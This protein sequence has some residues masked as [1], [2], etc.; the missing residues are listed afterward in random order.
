MMEHSSTVEEA[1]LQTEELAGKPPRRLGVLRG[2]LRREVWW[3]GCVLLVIAAAL[4]SADRSIGGGDTWVA[5]ANGRY[6]CAGDWA[7]EDEGRT[8]Q[9]KVLDVFGIHMTKKD[10]M[11][12]RTREYVPGDHQKFGWLNQNWLT[13]VTFYKM[14]EAWGENALLVYKFAQAILTALFAY[15]AARQRP[16]C[17]RKR[18]CWTYPVRRGLRFQ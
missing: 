5:M 3:L 4:H 14:R 8:W 6:T 11:G 13:H 10:Y 17:I 9:M 15:W 1:R 16:C 7:M 2:V 12:A 18:V